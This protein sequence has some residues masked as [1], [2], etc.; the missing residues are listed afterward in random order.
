MMEGVT[1]PLLFLGS[2]A[3]ARPWGL[4]KQSCTPLEARYSAEA[5]HSPFF[6]KTPAQIHTQALCVC[7]RVYYV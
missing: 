4:E 3:V 7:A 5:L 2:G 1:V 6:P